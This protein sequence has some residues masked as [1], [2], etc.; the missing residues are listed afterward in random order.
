MQIV[1]R[2]HPSAAMRSER[3]VNDL[4]M[5]GIGTT[6]ETNET[7]QPIRS[8][9]LQVKVTNPAM[10][11]PIGRAYREEKQR[12]QARDMNVAARSGNQRPD[13]VDG[14]LCPTH[15]CGQV[16][17]ADKPQGLQAW[18]LLLIG[19]AAALLFLRS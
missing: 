7:G 17:E 14:S 3:T 5:F 15:V 1:T 2:G 16:G 6:E 12:L 8:Q 10:R 19:G 18:P 4:S 11:A 13:E 9:E